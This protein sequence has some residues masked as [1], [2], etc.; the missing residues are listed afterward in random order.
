MAPPKSSS[1]DIDSSCKRNYSS[2]LSISGSKR[3]GRVNYE[4]NVP[5]QIRDLQ[6]SG[7]ISSNVN[8]NTSILADKHIAGNRRMPLSLIDQNVDSGPNFIRFP[9]SSSTFSNVKRAHFMQ[10]Q[11]SIPYSK[12]NDIFGSRKRNKSL[13]PSNSGDETNSG[14]KRCGRV[15]F[16]ANVPFQIH[17]L[18][19]RGPISANDIPNSS[20]S[21]EKH[22]S[23]NQRMPLSLIDQNVGIDK[24]FTTF[25]KPSSTF[26]SRQIKLI[27]NL[28][29][30]I[31]NGNAN[32]SRS[33]RR[34]PLIENPDFLKTIQLHN[35][36]EGSSSTMMKYSTPP[37][38]GFYNTHEEGIGMDHTPNFSALTTMSKYPTS[39][40]IRYSKDCVGSKVIASSTTSTIS[41]VSECNENE[42]N[43]SMDAIPFHFRGGRDE[44]LHT[45]YSSRLARPF[46]NPSINPKITHISNQPIENLSKSEQVL[47]KERLKECEAT[48][49]LLSS[50]DAASGDIERNFNDIEDNVDCGSGNSERGSE[51]DSDVDNL[52]DNDNPCYNFDASD[53]DGENNVIDYMSEKCL[54][55]KEY[56]SYKIMVRRE[57]GGTLRHS[58]RLF[59]QFVVDAFCAIEQYRLNWISV[60]D[61]FQRGL[62]HTPFLTIVVFRFIDDVE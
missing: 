16:E 53:E 30:R 58:G 8:P 4:A 20:V 23:G 61:T 38:E 26:K 51:D 31:H 21:M 15:N 1:K 42:V 5:F 9:K 11:Y 33:I 28:C 32:D 40:Q 6:R 56:Y 49:N 18:E 35:T 3:R 41:R 2:G 19:K 44:L 39:P 36:S 43:F 47:S 34:S 29:E 25:P 59:Q 46:L 13:G 12:E 7:P 27:S 48:K 24:S 17:D 50:F 10:N 60:F 37:P 14:S 55:M 57:D 54:T 45:H 22:I 52:D 62:I